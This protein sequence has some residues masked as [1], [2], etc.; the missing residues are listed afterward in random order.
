MSPAVL[1]FVLLVSTAI[2]NIESSKEFG[3]RKLL[4]NEEFSTDE[5]YLRV[6]KPEANRS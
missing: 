4:A 3:P 6:C 1:L 5:D 2:G